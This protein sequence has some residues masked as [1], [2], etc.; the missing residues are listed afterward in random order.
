MSYRCEICADVSPPGQPL[1]RHVVERHRPQTPWGAA[2]TEIAKEVAVCAR[3]AKDL[4]IA[5][6]DDLVNNRWLTKRSRLILE[7]TERQQR[8]QRRKELERTQRPSLLRKTKVP[9]PASIQAVRVLGPVLLGRSVQIT[10]RINPLN[11]N[12]TKE[13][14]NHATSKQ[15]DTHDNDSTPKTGPLS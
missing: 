3:C 12:K 6:I 9:T 11:S 8:L 4:Q 13:I 1:L 5:H 10:E 14:E 15:N 7:R 2:G